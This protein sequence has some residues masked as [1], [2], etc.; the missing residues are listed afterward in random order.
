[1]K[2][3]KDKTGCFPRRL[4][5]EEG[6]I[7]GI[8]EKHRQDLRRS[9]GEIDTLALPVDKFVE[10]YLPGA[11]KKD[12]MLDPFADLQ[13]TEGPNVLGATYFCDDHLEVKIDQ[14]VTK[15]A[16]R[17][18]QWGRY[19]ATGAHEGGHCVLHLVI[20]E[21]DPNQE[22]LFKSERT[23]KISCLQR[24]IEGEYTGEWW[25]YQANQIMANLLMP[26]ELFLDHFIRERNKFGIRDNT[27]L[28]KRRRLFDAL[29]T[30]LAR[31]FQVSK[32][33]VKI[34]LRELR[35]IPNLRQ[36]QFFG[37]DSLVRI[38]DVEIPGL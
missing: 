17:T 37:N 5:F 35:Q 31:V 27:E 1:M 20:F 25:E 7:E 30:Y 21:G 2:I 14:R 9:I 15:E 36:E 22:S 4:W 6:E 18:G 23:R 8:A 34:R 26:A 38:G 11:L 13:S 12:I 28:P 3:I 32:Q 29:V 10:I 24:T 19:N 33:A 16:E